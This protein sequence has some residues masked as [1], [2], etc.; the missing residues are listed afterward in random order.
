MFLSLVIQIAH[1]ATAFGIIKNIIWS[2]WLV[3]MWIIYLDSDSV[4][5]ALE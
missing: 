1:I 5:K 3:I 2:F 4:F